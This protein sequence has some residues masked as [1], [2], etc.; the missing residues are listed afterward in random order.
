MYA[1]ELPY[2]LVFAAK[3]YH[4]FRNRRR[5]PCKVISIGNITVG[6]TGKT[7]ASV[8]VALEANR[9]GL[10]PII[11]TRGYRGTAKGP[12]FVTRGKGPLLSVEAA[13]D[14]PFLMAERLRDIAIVKGRNRYE[15]GMLAM[16]EFSGAE[17]I[18]GYQSPAPDLFILDDGFQHWGLYRDRDIVLIDAG[19]PFGNGLLLPFGRLREPVESLER[20]DIIVLTKAEAY[21]G[22]NHS[23]F[24]KR[25]EDLI[26]T[27]RRHNAKSQIFFARHVPVSCRLLSGEKKPFEW[28]AGKKISGFCALGAPESFKRTL[29]SA[30][31]DLVSYRTFRDH[32]RY[33][34]ADI[35][36]I[37]KEAAMHGAEWIVT[38]EKDIIKIRN[39]DLPVNILVIEIDFFVEGNFYDEVFNL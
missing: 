4:A 31:S 34:A 36:E 11:L 26:K 28:I 15:S 10:N 20:A 35:I 25:V 39:L 5:L 17:E 2:Y 27:I 21:E 30:G 1:F 22:E 16:K 12:C 37:K 7:P 19:D 33:S 32:H 9:R 8:A 18:S 13:G 14:E 38:T 6:G 3:K 24:G 29:R 23:T